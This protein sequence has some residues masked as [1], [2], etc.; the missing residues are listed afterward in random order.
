MV[1]VL[2]VVILSIKE[3]RYIIRKSSETNKRTST[4]F[5]NTELVDHFNLITVAWV[6]F[7]CSV[8]VESLRII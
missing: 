4:I 3:Y 1:S 8:L 5:W 6:Y 7:I 2:M